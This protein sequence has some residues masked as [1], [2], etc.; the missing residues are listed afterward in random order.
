MTP[1]DEGDMPLLVD[2]AVVGRSP[3]KAFLSHSSKDKFYVE[4]VAKSLGR[5]YIIYDSF[6]FDHGK[7]F[8]DE[9]LAGLDKSRVFVYF[10]SKHSLDS[11]WVDF[12]L[13]EAQKR[14]FGSQMAKAIA[15]RLDRTISI[16]DLPHWMQRENIPFLESPSVAARL[17]RD[18]INDIKRSSTPD[19]FIGR[20][21]DI[22]RVEHALAPAN[23][24]RPPG[25]VALWGLPGIGRRSVGKRI[26][27]DI[28][29]MQRS[30][31]IEIEQG[32]S[33]GDLR[34]KLAALLDTPKSS[35]AYTALQKATEQD[36]DLTNL[37]ECIRYIETAQ[38]ARE[39]ILL[40]DHG[41][42]LDEDGKLLNVFGEFIL[43]LYR[44]ETLRMV[45]VSRR[46]PQ[47]FELEPGSYL[48]EVRIDNLS[49]QSTKT[50]IQQLRAREQINLA[51]SEIDDLA[52][53]IRGYPPAA[54][55]AIGLIKD[56]GKEAIL[57]DA[58]HIISFR[59]SSFLRLL[60]KDSK[61]SSTQRS[62]LS[63]L[64]QFDSLPLPVL[65]KALQMDQTSIDIEAMRLVD[66]ALLSI[67]EDGYYSVSD[68]VREAAHR[69]FGKVN[70]PYKEIAQAIDDYRDERRADPS[71]LA[72][73]LSL[74]RARFKAYVLSGKGSAGIFRIASDLTRLQQTLYHNQEYE[75]S[76]QLGQQVLEMR[77]KQPEALKFL[78]RGFAQLERYSEA[79]KT[80]DV[81]RSVSLK[82]AKFLE[83]FLYRKQ[84][85]MNK[86]VVAYRE[87]LALGM[88]GAA[89]HRELGQ[90][91]FEEGLLED[92]REHLSRAH[93]VDPDNKFVIDYSIQ[94]AIAEKRFPDAKKLIVELERVEDDTRVQH[95]LS[96]LEAATGNASRAFEAAQRAIDSSARPHFEVISQYV[97]MA[98][99]NKRPDLALKGLEML[100]NR[101]SNIRSDIQNGLW[102]QY[103]ICT[104][105]FDSAS[106]KWSAIKRKDLPVHR[107]IRVHILE[108]IL[109]TRALTA[110]HRS[111]IQSELDQLHSKDDMALALALSEFDLE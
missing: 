79:T 45:I 96:T 35:E 15:I 81:L 83:G 95:R 109:K 3:M 99:W 59:E 1:T 58:S 21:Q 98:I 76:V 51:I 41:G 88:K 86:A 48:P 72:E 46:K 111:E 90:C 94:V 57:R 16:S 103:Y 4:A 39:L 61:L 104:E 5:E 26:S 25:I 102:S 69:A 36:S 87:A 78:A 28:L 40:V 6:S 27:K 18:H 75:K 11:Y 54:Y 68:P 73:P 80:I 29:D 107:R 8:K 9:I 14:L 50:L 22:E 42:L 32:D 93:S 64:P 101:F 108:G 33:L 97:K 13:T 53:R 77:P 2:H 84:G 74:L 110:A 49:M 34:L 100:S 91:L 106:T 30:L 62:I 85:A 20:S 82:E 38:A 52:E 56:Y 44:A 10:I 37:R 7:A 65:G 17:I 92:A 24:H 12:E 63:I 43:A 66:M 70:L 47:R 60:E 67:D 19:L 71:E 89:V 31:A 23:D 105:D 55:Y